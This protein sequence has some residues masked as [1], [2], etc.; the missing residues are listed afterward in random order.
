MQVFLYAKHRLQYTARRAKLKFK[1]IES[2]LVG[3]LSVHPAVHYLYHHF[4]GGRDYR[5][6]LVPAEHLAL[7]VACA[8]VQV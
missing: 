5:A 4:A 2:Y 8:H 3:E 6:V 7:F 1:K